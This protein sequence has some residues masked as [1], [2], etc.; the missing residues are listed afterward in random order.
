ECGFISHSMMILEKLILHEVDH[1]EKLVLWEIFQNLEK[2]L[3]NVL[4]LVL[5]DYL[6]MK[7]PGQWKLTQENRLK[8]QLLEQQLLK[9]DKQH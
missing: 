3:E 2:C 8:P 9:L 4:V 1:H 5:M 6:L 7:H